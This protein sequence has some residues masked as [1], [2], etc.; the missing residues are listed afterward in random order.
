[1]QFVLEKYFHEPP[2]NVCMFTYYMQFVL[3]KV[4]SRMYVC[5]MAVKG[6]TKAYSKYEINKK[7]ELVKET[8]K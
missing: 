4:S 1:M 2:R 3:E 8:K 5:L 6:F 7:Y